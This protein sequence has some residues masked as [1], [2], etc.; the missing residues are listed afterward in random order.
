MGCRIWPMLKDLGRRWQSYLVSQDSCLPLQEWISSFI[1]VR[2]SNF[3]QTPD[4]FL[5]QHKTPQFVCGIIK[6]HDASRHTPVMWTGRIAFQHALLHWKDHTS[7]VEAKIVKYIFGTYRLV[8][9]YKYLKVIV[10]I[11]F[12]LIITAVTLI[13]LL[14]DIVL[15]VAVRLFSLIWSVL[16]QLDC[17]D[18]SS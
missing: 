12:I 9:F 6:R 16:T 8:K 15:A 7:L 4:L 11:I 5:P 18:T 2:M 3:L 1:S 10:V 13:L 14:E 17:L